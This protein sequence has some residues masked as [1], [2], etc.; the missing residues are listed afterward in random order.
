[1]CQF[2][3]AASTEC[4]GEHSL[5]TN[6]YETT[7]ETGVVREYWWELVNGTARV[8]GVE[9]VVLTVNG[10][11]PGPTIFAD[12]GDEVVVH[13]T[14]D[15][16]VVLGIGLALVA[17]GTRVHLLELHHLLLTLFLLILLP[18]VTPA[19]GHHL[20]AAAKDG[21]HGHA[22]RLCHVDG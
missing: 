22:K 2:N 10:S 13:V 19:L 4:W 5:S 3:S 14:L 20:L 15:V 17:P 7:P 6:W 8:D 18:H 16:V 1:M 11:F 9:R 12:W 21:G